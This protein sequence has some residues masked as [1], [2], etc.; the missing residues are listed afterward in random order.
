MDEY[1]LLVNKQY[2]D[3]AVSVGA[4]SRREAMPLGLSASSSQTSLLQNSAGY[5][6]A[7]IDLVI[8]IVISGYAIAILAIAIAISAIAIVI[9]AIKDMAEQVSVCVRISGNRKM[10]WRSPPQ[11]SLLTL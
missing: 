7:F 5:A 4:A 11:A 10:R 6:N 1:F 2:T 8:A 9:S 3:F